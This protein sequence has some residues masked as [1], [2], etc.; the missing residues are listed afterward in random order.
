M[1]LSLTLAGRTVTP[2]SSTGTTTTTNKSADLGLIRNVVGDVLANR[3]KGIEYTA[4]GNAQRTTAAGYGAEEAAYGA[5]A[6]S[7]DQNAVYAK[8]T[9]DILSIQS[10]RATARTLGKQQAELAGSGFSADTGSAVDQVRS[11]VQEGYLADQ[12]IR[13]QSSFDAAGYSN[14]AAASRAQL[15]AA[16]FAQGTALDTAGVYDSAA[17]QAKTNAANE[18]TGLSGYLSQ[19]KTLKTTADQLLSGQDIGTEIALGPHVTDTSTTS[20][21]SQGSP[22]FIAA[23][24]TNTGFGYYK[25]LEDAPGGKIVNDRSGQT[26]DPKTL[27]NVNP[28][29]TGATTA[30]TTT[31]GI[32]DPFRPPTRSF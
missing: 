5:S 19:F 16:K 3:A 1:P 15:A 25:G 2:T 28:A 7:S 29:V 9:G 23:A 8:A 30:T 18:T 4:A 26:V 20:T 14:Q 24:G 31:T 6:T 10:Q 17:A 21:T 12:L 22:T 27:G 11:S 32:N 13:T